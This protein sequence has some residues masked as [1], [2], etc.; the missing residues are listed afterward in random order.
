MES[1]VNINESRR[2]RKIVKQL[3]QVGWSKVENIDQDF[4]KLTLIYRDQN[5]EKVNLYKYQI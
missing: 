3:K 4:Q 2:L 5:T 1:E